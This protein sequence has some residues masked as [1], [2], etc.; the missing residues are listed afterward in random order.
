M[1]IDRSFGVDCLQSFTKAR[2][3]TE[4]REIV[5]VKLA[6]LDALIGKLSVIK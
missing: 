4:Q 2:H 5:E 6:E 3:Q 1:Y